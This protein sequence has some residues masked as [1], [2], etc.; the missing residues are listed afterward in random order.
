MIVDCH[1][2]ATTSLVV[3]E[4]MGNCAASRVIVRD[5]S[6]VLLLVHDHE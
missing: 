5:D 3:V 4:C 6:G 1:P 2:H